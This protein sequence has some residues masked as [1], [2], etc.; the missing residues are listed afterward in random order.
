M[1]DGSQSTEGS[2]TTRAWAQRWLSAERLAPY[3]AA[4]DGDPERAIEL[5]EW[6]IGLGQAILRDI[7][8][9]E[10]ALR[11]ACDR[12]MRESWGEGW[13]T[14]GDSPA[15]RPVMRSSARGQLDANRINR[16]TIDAA[17]DRLP[18]NYEHGDLVA[19]LMLGFWVHLADRSR[20]V[21]IWR[22]GLY[23]A[24]P[25]GTRRQ[26]LQQ[27]LYGILTM[28]NRVAHVE[29][30]FDPKGT[31]PSPRAVDEDAVRLFGELCPEARACLYVDGK[32]GVEAF[33]QEKPAP[34][35]VRL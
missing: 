15:R 25:A 23:R 22:T 24:W 10:V 7:S 19:A 1:A 17:I 8:H 27:S 4:C 11:N 21:V 31:S 30:L 14:D 35:R 18:S 12:A 33:T 13:L 3:L 5:Y 32:T 9:L 20:E 2:M 16:K 26:D 34:V 6:N 29:R 28:R